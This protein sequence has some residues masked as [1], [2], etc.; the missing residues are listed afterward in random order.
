M[1][2]KLHHNIRDLGFPQHAEFRGFS[3]FCAESWNFVFFRGI[4]E[5]IVFEHK[6]VENGEFSVPS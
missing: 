3:N 1:L 4:V 2:C 6:I 5:I